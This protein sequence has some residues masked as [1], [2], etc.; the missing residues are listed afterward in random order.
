MSESMRRE[1][2]ETIF[3]GRMGFGLVDRNRLGQSCEGHTTRRF[4]VEPETPPDYHLN[5]QKKDERAGKYYSPSIA[6]V[7]NWAI[8]GARIPLPAPSNSRF[9]SSHKEKASHMG[10]GSK[11]LNA[12]G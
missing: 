11:C 4:W 5:S 1:C 6:A 9:V 8:Q 12:F 3:I 7:Q 2:S 10:V